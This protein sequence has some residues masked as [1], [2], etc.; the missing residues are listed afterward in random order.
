MNSCATELGLFLGKI[1]RSYTVTVS[2]SGRVALTLASGD[3]L[4]WTHWDPLVCEDRPG[5][6]LKGLLHSLMH[7][8]EACGNQPGHLLT[9]HSPGIAS[10]LACTTSCVRLATAAGG[11]GWE[12][13]LPPVAAH[14]DGRPAALFTFGVPFPVGHKR[15]IL[16]TV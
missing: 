9:S 3:L 1:S 14:L 12:L 4:C 2:P 16:Q 6:A 5:Q 13:C 7:R 8:R 15:H 11:Q 10:S